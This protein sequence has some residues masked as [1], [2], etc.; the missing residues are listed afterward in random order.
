MSI[1]TLIQ[2]A[3]NLERVGLWRRAATQW[4]AVMDHC[5]DD[6]EWEQIARRREPCLLTSQGHQKNGGEKFVIV[7]AVRSDIKTGI[8]RY[9]R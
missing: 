7:T 6:S 8:N 1:E 9:L 2:K 3:T 4:L 5:T